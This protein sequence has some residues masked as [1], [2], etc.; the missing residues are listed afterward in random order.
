MNFSDPK[1]WFPYGRKHV[2]NVV[3]IDSFSIYT[4]FTTQL[5]N[6]HDHME[7][8]LKQYSFVRTP[9]NIFFITLIF[10]T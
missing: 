4:T 6:I 1:A 3:E 5:R 7:T 2:V 10:F 8:R 9:G